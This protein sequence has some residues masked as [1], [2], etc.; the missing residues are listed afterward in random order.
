MGA[1]GLF[2]LDAVQ[3]WRRAMA[4]VLAVSLVPGYALAA[5]ITVFAAASLKNAMDEVA[6][7]FER[8]TGHRAVMSFAASSVLARQIQF[9][10]P[11]DVFISA[12]TEWMD[13]LQREGLIAADSRFDLA[14]NRLVL[15]A[16]DQFTA[17]VSISSDVNLA[18]L[19]GDSYLA[20]A[21]VDAVPVGIYGKTALEHL[22]LWDSVS[23]NVAQSDNARAALAL[24][25]S[26]EARFGIVYATDAKADANVSIIGAFPATAHAPIVYPVA[27]VSQGRIAL[28]EEFLN[29][30]RKP[31]ATEIIGRHGFTKP[32]EAN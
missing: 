23:A 5:E 21:L 25:S 13:L 32:A 3:L 9:G 16:H 28:A 20:M 22:G 29:F 14:G 8:E 11:A 6:E 31:V 4:V 7:Q 1:S 12:N 10:A 19:L 18:G 17:Q 2:G 24:V 30:L 26:G 15:I 27:A